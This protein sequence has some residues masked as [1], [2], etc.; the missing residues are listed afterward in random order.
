MN[1][2]NAV[3]VEIYSREELKRLNPLHGKG[4]FAKGKMSKMNQECLQLVLRFAEHY[5]QWG[6]SYPGIEQEN[7]G[8][9]SRDKVQ[10]SLNKK[11]LNSGSPIR[12]VRFSETIPHTPCLR[13][14]FY[15]PFFVVGKRADAIKVV[16]R[17]EGILLC[18]PFELELKE[19][20]EKTIEGEVLLG[21]YYRE[22]KRTK[23]C[24]FSY[25]KKAVEDLRSYCEK[26]YTQLLNA[27]IPS[28]DSSFEFMF[29]DN[30]T[31]QA[32][33]YVHT[34]VFGRPTAAPQKDWVWYKSLSFNEYC[35]YIEEHLPKIQEEIGKKFSLSDSM[36][37]IMLDAIFSH[38]RG[39][40]YQKVV[41]DNR[42][43][44]LELTIL[45]VFEDAGYI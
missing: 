15:V 27:A 45:K 25:N 30:Q 26:V 2:T 40:F 32:G 35:A 19:Y 43:T 41:V 31:R 3:K 29:M 34:I 23:K 9:P 17:K 8:S 22:N 11:F 20:L 12:S 4:H 18:R 38:Y 10:N 5:T 24:G 14:K 36:R 13:E 1:T 37:V 28:V 39:D 44:R 16:K 21:K 7:L 42:R 6:S 33:C